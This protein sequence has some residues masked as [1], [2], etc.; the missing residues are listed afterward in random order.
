[1][2]IY[3][4]PPPRKGRGAKGSVYLPNPSIKRKTWRKGECV[5]TQPLYQEKDVTQRGVCIYPTPPSR[6]G[7]DAKRSVYLPNPPPR[8]GHD[9]KGSVYLPNPSTKRRT[10]HKGECVFTQPLHQ[11]EDVTQSQF[12]NRKMLVSIPLFPFPDLQFI[13]CNLSELS[14]GS[15]WVPCTYGCSSPKQNLVNGPQ[16]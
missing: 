10:W 8:E 1:M 4:T 3:P 5:F 13:H 12:L 11:E 9:A 16:L 2:C 7:R 15:H 14:G 6:R